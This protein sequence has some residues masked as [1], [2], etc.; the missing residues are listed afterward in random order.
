MLKSPWAIWITG[1]SGS[2]KTTI[3]KKLMRLMEKGGIEA[4]FLRMDEIRQFVTPSPEFSLPEKEVVYRTAAYLAY[5]LTGRGINVI[6]DSVDAHGVGRKLARKLIPNFHVVYIR[7]PLEVCIE[8]E[9]VR[10]DRA[11]IEK[12]YERAGRGEIKV[13]GM[14]YPY[15]EEK[16]HLL[17]ID[18]ERTGATEAAQMIFEKINN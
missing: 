8:R 6:I 14:G 3:A 7:C 5:R 9:R 12:L 11:K 18:S 10:K 13:A 15:T 16:K 4:E 17:L 1:L 2:G